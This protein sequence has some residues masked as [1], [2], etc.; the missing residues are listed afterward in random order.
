[1]LPHSTTLASN[2]SQSKNAIRYEAY[3]KGSPDH[4]ESL[5]EAP[6]DVV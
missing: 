5:S 4:R 3:G 2:N 1:M 6:T